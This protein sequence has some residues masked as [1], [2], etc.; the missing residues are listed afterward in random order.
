LKT[1]ALWERVE[2]EKKHL[3]DSPSTVLESSLAKKIG[4]QLG[5]KTS[6]GVEALDECAHAKASC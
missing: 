1:E 4:A 5:R 6:G 3:S 2:K